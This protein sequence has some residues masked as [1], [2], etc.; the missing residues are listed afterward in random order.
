[1]FNMGTE[2]NSGKNRHTLE[3][4]RCFEHVR[5]MSKTTDRVLEERRELKDGKVLGHTSLAEG[6]KQSEKEAAMNHQCHHIIIL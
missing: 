3:A 1:M 4:R 5:T 6:P 2:G